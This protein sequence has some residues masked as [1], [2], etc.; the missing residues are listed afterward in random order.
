LGFAA[1][2]TIGYGFAAAQSSGGIGSAESTLIVRGLLSPAG[3]GAW[4]G[5]VCATLWRERE[6]AGRRIVDVPVV[7]AWAAA[8]SLHA[9]WDI[10]NTQTGPTLIGAI[11][12]ELGSAVIAL[13]SLGLLFHMVNEAARRRPTYVPGCSPQTG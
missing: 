12:L 10:F 7:A 8:V 2:E 11:G 4:T 13:L 1:F 9:L 6:K 3:H 5:L